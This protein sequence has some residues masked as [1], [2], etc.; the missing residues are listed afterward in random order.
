MDTSKIDTEY[1]ALEIGAT[2]IALNE[3][4]GNTAEG[5]AKLE[6]ARWLK[7][8]L[9]FDE[10][11][12][13]LNIP[14]GDPLTVGNAIADY[15]RRVG[16][17]DT[18]LHKISDN[19]MVYEMK[20]AVMQSWFPM[21]DARHAQNPLR[22]L[23]AAALFRAAFKKLCNMKLDIITVSDEIRATTLKGKSGQLWR[24]SPITSK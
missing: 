24:L 10:I 14:A 8:D 7:G 16:S 19:E 11:Q 13:Q 6:E 4:F 5:R 22:P 3:L 23:P 20:Q 17:S 1:F 2:W 21:F 12:K 9:V 15:L 18:Q